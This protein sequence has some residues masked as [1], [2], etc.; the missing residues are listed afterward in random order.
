M[1]KSSYVDYVVSDALSRLEGVTARAMFG[2]HGLYLNGTI[3]GLIADEVLY[4]KTDGSNRGE[5]EE[6]G[7]KPFSYEGRR[8]RKITLSYWELP[9]EILDDADLVAEWARRAARVSMNKK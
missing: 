7:S 9:S 5:Y 2:G 1:K 4:F 3:F 6:L 8:G